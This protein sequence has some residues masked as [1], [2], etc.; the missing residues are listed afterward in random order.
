MELIL[1]KLKLPPNSIY[2]ALIKC[3]NKILSLP[4]LE[5][6]DVINPTEEEISTV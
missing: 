1:M 2:E 6:L 4:T 5:S 3:N